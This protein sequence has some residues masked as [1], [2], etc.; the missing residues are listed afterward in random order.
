MPT[1]AHDIEGCFADDDETVINYKGE[2]YYKACGHIVMD[3]GDGTS[4]CVKRQ[5]HQSLTH[6]DYDGQIRIR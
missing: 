6:E 2:N 5:G 4:S 3:Y 1:G